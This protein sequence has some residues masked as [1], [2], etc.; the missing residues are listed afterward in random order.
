MLGFKL[1]SNVASTIFYRLAVV[2]IM[3]AVQ[4]RFHVLAFYKE[5]KKN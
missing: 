3:H 1:P 4:I 5:R 2:Y